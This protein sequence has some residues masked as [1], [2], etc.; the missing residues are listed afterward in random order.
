MRLDGETESA[1]GRLPRSF[2]APF[3]D[4]SADF[5]MLRTHTCGQLRAES[6]GS[7]VTLCGWVQRV[8][9]K[10]AV[11]WVDLRDR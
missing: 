4:T 10:G 6:I 11:L 5:P 2:A 3:C 1:P 7:T 8:R 9:D